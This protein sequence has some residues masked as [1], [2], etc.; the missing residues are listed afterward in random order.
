MQR[1]FRETVGVVGVQLDRPAVVNQPAALGADR[2]PG[3]RSEAFVVRQEVQT[4]GMTGR[5][6]HG[7]SEGCPDDLTT[8]RAVTAEQQV[9]ELVAVYQVRITEKPGRRGLRM[10]KA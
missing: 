5:L 8:D 9:E 6:C 10:G 2:V 4:Q 7:E 1:I 3:E